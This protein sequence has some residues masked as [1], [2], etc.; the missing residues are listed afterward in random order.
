MHYDNID[1]YNLVD[2]MV[3]KLVPKLIGLVGSRYISY[4]IYDLTSASQL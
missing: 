4:I 3:F 1:N 2:G